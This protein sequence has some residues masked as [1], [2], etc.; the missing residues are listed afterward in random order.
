MFENLENRRLMSVTLSDTGTLTI[1][2]S[3][4]PDDVG[5]WQSGSELLKVDHNGSVSTFAVDKVKSIFV[6]VGAGNDRVIIGKRSAAAT[7]VGNSGNDVLSA[8]NGN[9]FL[10]GGEG[11][12]YLFGREGDDKLDGG[13]GADTILGGAGR[14]TVD[15]SQR[16]NPVY[17]S[18]GNTSPDGERNEGDR[19]C[20]DIERVLGGRGSDH[21]RNSSNQ[22]VILI[23]GKGHDKL[24][25]RYADDLLYGGPGRDQFRGVGGLKY[26]NSLV[27][28]DRSADQIFI[29]GT[30]LD[31]IKA[32][33]LDL[34][35]VK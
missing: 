23:G 11:D 10:H 19:V 31:A 4:R 35:H 7:L 28:A 33:K 25:A 24:D 13:A 6:D 5:L 32:D 9:D 21:L 27:T 20:G 22:P 18:V 8:G 14:D 3:N 30:T 17:V 15:Y 29:G 26:I 2:G 12:D 34:V 1:L 16:W